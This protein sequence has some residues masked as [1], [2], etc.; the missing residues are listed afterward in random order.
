MFV[1][2]VA[3]IDITDQSTS[4]V[5]GIF[6][7]VKYRN[8]TAISIPLWTT[9]H[10]IG[11]IPP[12]DD[13]PPKVYSELDRI[14]DFLVRVILCHSLNATQHKINGGDGRLSS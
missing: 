13:R 4:M 8:L 10:C 7:C 9:E 12:Q 11:V 1:S 14:T 5:T 3:S 2:T 6:G